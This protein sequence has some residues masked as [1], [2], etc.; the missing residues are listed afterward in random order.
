MKDSFK[1]MFPLDGK[2]LSMTG[3]SEKYILKNCLHMP[4]N[5]FPVPG[6][7]HSLKNTFPLYK[8]SASSGKKI[9]EN[10]FH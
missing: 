4:E 7:K 3:V 6:T 10:S 1:N 2:K 5:Q 8:K 9:E